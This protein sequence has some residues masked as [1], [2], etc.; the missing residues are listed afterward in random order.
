MPTTLCT[1][2]MQKENFYHIQIQLK[3]CSPL[4]QFL[5]RYNVFTR[6]VRNITK[7]Q[8]SCSPVFKNNLFHFS[9]TKTISNGY[10]IVVVSTEALV[11]V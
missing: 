6:T 7:Y 10:L 11:R 2:F 3:T 4:L 5:Q 8:N 1:L 9:E